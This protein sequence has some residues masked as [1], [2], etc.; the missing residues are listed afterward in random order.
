MDNRLLER[1]KPCTAAPE[2]NADLL[3]NTEVL[4]TEEKGALETYNAG[5]VARA[6]LQK[7]SPPAQPGDVPEFRA[8][9]SLLFEAEPTHSEDRPQLCSNIHMYAFGL[10][11]YQKRTPRFQEN[12]ITEHPGNAAWIAA[13]SFHLR[14]GTTD[15]PELVQHKCKLARLRP[16][17]WRFCTEEWKRLDRVIPKCDRWPSFR[18]WVLVAA[19]CPFGAEKAGFQWLANFSASSFQHLVEEKCRRSFTGDSDILF[20]TCEVIYFWGVHI[21]GR[22]YFRSKEDPYVNSGYGGWVD[23]RIPKR[24]TVPAVKAA[25]QKA[26][27]LSVCQKRLWSLAPSAERGEEEFPALIEVVERSPVPAQFSQEGHSQCTSDY[28]QLADENTTLKK[29]LHKCTES[30]RCQLVPFPLHELN[31]AAMND[32]STAWRIE[33]SRT[34]KSAK[35]ASTAAEQE[36]K[37]ISLSPS[38]EK[39]IAI[40]HV[41][42]DGTGVGV[43]QV[44]KVNRCLLSYFI[45]LAEEL[46]CNGIW[47][48]TICIPSDREARRRAIGRMNSYY[49]NAQHTVIHDEYLLQMDWS[50]DGSPAL[51]IVLSPWFTRGW[52]ALELSIST[53]VKVLFRDPHD[54]NK[55]V[56]KDLDHDVLAHTTGFSSRGHYVAS[57]LLWRLRGQKPTLADLLKILNT[58]AT[59]WPRDRLAI[60]GL[61]ARAEDMD[62]SDSQKETTLKV[63]KSY[64]EIPRSFLL[65]GHVTLAEAGGFSWC[66]SNF[67]HSELALIADRDE[68]LLSLTPSGQVCG[69]W[70]YRTLTVEDTEWLRLHSHHPSVELRIRDAFQWWDHCLLLHRYLKNTFTVPAILVL[71]ADVGTIEKYG[72]VM[73]VWIESSYVGCVFDHTQGRVQ[74]EVDA[75]IGTD[76]TQVM[77]AATALEQ[78]YGAEARMPREIFLGRQSD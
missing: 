76:S 3:N 44:G 40:S 11:P 31:N 1:S 62:Y 2:I 43:Q 42:S 38:P 24:V 78:Y 4:T 6:R 56:I 13:E 71:V 52:T 27:Q 49:A 63:V 57:A 39:Y 64:V 14:D 22:R 67:L 66:P 25:V 21:E 50:D 70:W 54:H 51:A 69:S 26:R 47:W 10:E 16:C 34:G 74:H 68:E 55:Q 37:Q 73:D 75:R 23:S 7:P 9:D 30:E 17:K 5:I 48:D 58:R 46:D 15:L 53:S 29:Q 77:P 20:Q 60:A 35:A 45:H 8:D 65:H 19:S 59:S 61:L 28:C 32:M 12:V 72:A 36:V 18:D 33:A 41:W